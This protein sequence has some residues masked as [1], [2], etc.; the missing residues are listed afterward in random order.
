MTT[1]TAATTTANDRPANHPS[2]ARWLPVQR[3]AAAT[4]ALVFVF[5]QVVVAEAF[6][7]PLAV[8]M[9]AFTLAL[10]ASFR[11]QRGGAI[12]IGVLGALSFLAFIPDILRD[13]SRPASNYIFWG[14]GLA[15]IA[16]LVAAIG[17]IPI[18]LRKNSALAS[19]AVHVTAA[20]AV[21]VVFS[22][23][24]MAR[25]TLDSHAAEPGD[26][27]VA[28]ENVYFVPGDI[29]ADAGTIAFHVENRDRGHH[30]FTIDALGVQVQLPERSA[31]RFVFDAPPGVY[32]ITC[33]LPGHGRM[34]ATLVVN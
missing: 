9:A 14:T 25:L 5:F 22:V 32:E 6:I 33:T 4:V 24:M 3:I 13:M 12:A 7:P 20:V 34:V 11:W 23:G 30:D 15:A 1:T 29:E 31:R 26:L 21:V 27:I 2:L 18:I 28:A 8:V 10:L 17:G 16:V 19:R